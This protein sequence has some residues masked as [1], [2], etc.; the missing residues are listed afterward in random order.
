MRPFADAMMQ[1]FLQMFASSSAGQNA[2][3][4]EDALL[5]V[6]SLTS[7]LEKDFIRYME[8]FLPFLYAGLQNHQEYQVG[9]K[10]KNQTIKQANLFFFLFLTPFYLIVQ[11]CSISVGLVGDICRALGESVLPYCN[12]FMTFLLQNLQVW[13]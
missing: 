4:L 8:A 13:L 6:G 5:A 1:T 10:E 11:V 12:T 2:T 3:I 7:T 9:K